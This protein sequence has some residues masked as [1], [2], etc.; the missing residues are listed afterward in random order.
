MT[1]AATRTTKSRCLALVE[2]EVLGIIEPVGAALPR[3]HR[4]QLL[5]LRRLVA[6]ASSPAKRAS[7]WFYFHISGSSLL[8]SFPKITAGSWQR[9]YREAVAA[10]RQALPRFAAALGPR[11][12]SISS[13]AKRLRRGCEEGRNRF[14]VEVTS[15]PP[16]QRSREARQRWAGGRNRF[17]VVPRQQNAFARFPSDICG[18]QPAGELRGRPTG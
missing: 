4:W 13:T 8:V 7:Y 11:Q 1:A 18:R 15:N 14:A 3:N 5:S 2:L 6:G 17:A 9:A 16:T 10:S 12:H